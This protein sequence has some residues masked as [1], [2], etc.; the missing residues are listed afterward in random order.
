[1]IGRVRS[2]AVL[3]V[4]LVAMPSMAGCAMTSDYPGDQPGDPIDVAR[5]VAAP[6]FPAE[7][8]H[9]Y[10]FPSH[11]DPQRVRC[12]LDLWVP[13][14]EPSADVGTRYCRVITRLRKH[15]HAATS[16]GRPFDWYEVLLSGASDQPNE[17][18][19]CEGESAGA[20]GYVGSP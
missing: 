2:I 5:S 18:P 3:A 4:A 14:S 11:A 7:Q 19:I 1:M 6:E 15:P 13:A 20:A 9:T 8:V 16:D 17:P 10:C 12:D